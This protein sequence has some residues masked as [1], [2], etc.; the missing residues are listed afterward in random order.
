MRILVLRLSALGDIIHTMPAVI[1]LRNGLT[2]E[3]GE[4][5]WVV[6]APYAE[7]VQIVAEV[8]PVAVQMKAWGRS[9]LRSREQI[10]EALRAMRGARVA[11]DFQGL[12]K[13]AVLAR[14]SGAPIRYGFDRQAIRETPAT[15]FTNRHI[16]VDRTRHVVEWNMELAGAIIPTTSH[17]PSVD[18]KPFACDSR[19]R[20]E[21]YRDSIVLLPGAGRSEKQWPAERFRELVRS[22]QGRT[23]VVWGPGER[24][25]AESIGGRIA[26]E[27]NLRE[28]AFLLQHAKIVV[29]GDTGPLHLAAAL[30]TLVVGL[31][32]PTDPRRNGPYGQIASCID[33]FSRTKS[34]R[35]IGVDEVMKK[36]DEVLK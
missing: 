12:I 28:L 31:Y 36:I 32:G 9:P 35:A 5:R 34:M 15:L 2:A 33:E 17:P 29:G 23:L 30:G 18:F 22:H 4:I 21:H 26:P 19:N 1:A 14:L 11:V 16:S 20:L 8:T 27:T 7:L 3:G 10:G 25:L 24:S 13:S 6:E